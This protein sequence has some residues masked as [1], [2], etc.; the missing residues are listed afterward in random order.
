MGRYYYGDIDGK[1]W[2]GTQDSDDAI[3]FGVE[4]IHSIQYCYTC[5]CED[6]EDYCD[7]EVEYEDPCEKCGCDYECEEQDNENEV[8]FYFNE[9]H[10]DDIQK[11]L[12]DIQEVL[13]DIPM[14]V[15]EDESTTFEMKD[16]EYQNDEH[17]KLQARWCLGQQILRCIKETG[18]CDFK[19]GS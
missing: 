16:L 11:V 18:E 10:V 13:P 14:P 2:V 7:E 8:G 9:M 19:C 3:N 12:D 6:F 5:G 4:P 1:F 17:E 15:F